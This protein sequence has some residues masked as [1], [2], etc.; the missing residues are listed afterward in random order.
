MPNVSLLALLQLAIPRAAA[1]TTP[2]GRSRA[3]AANAAQNVTIENDSSAITYTPP[4]CDASTQC[5]NSTGGWRIQLLPG[6]PANTTTSTDGPD[7]QSGGIIPQMFLTFKGPSAHTPRAQPS[8]TD[9]SG[10]TASAVYVHVTPDSNA[11]VNMTLTSVPADVVRSSAVD[12]SAVG[13]TVAAVGLDEAQ[14]TTL[15]LTLASP[16]GAVLGIDSISLTVSAPE[17]S[18]SFLPSATLPPSS[19]L[20]TIAVPTASPAGAASDHATAEGLGIGIG[21]GV[22]LV[23]AGLAVTFLFW[24]RWKRRRKER[25]VGQEAEMVWFN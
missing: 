10:R 24:R 3:R 9:S 1:H 13:G 25:Q 6:T 8:R 14:T 16:S 19:A 22:P 21:L 23:L 2:I 17:A 18:G 4:A 12:T 7:P 15:V 11:T 20:P 5:G